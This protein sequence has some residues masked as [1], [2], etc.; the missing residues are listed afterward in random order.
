MRKSIVVAA[1][2]IGV[3]ALQASA[4]EAGGLRVEQA[5]WAEGQLYGTVLTPTAFV[6]PPV[7]S[8]DALYNFSMSG[9]SGQR[10][11]S[12][13]SPGDPDYNG[14]RWS[15]KMVVF[16]PQGKTVHDP[17]GDGAINIELTSVSQVHEQETLGNL[18]IFDTTTYFECPM[19][20]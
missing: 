15:V 8:T 18:T 9:L 13:S 10:S 3:G 16:T 12:E 20:P 6:S 14:G 2:A 4:A 11:V 17:D 5:I 1:L 7:H 19:L